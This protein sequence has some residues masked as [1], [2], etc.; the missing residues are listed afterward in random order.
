MEGFSAVPVCTSM[1]NLLNTAISSLIHVS[2]SAR[3]VK[4]TA[5]SSAYSDVRNRHTAP[6]DFDVWPVSMRSFD[7]RNVQGLVVDVERQ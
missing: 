6:A 1:P 4:D 3:L 2:A 5:A 7:D